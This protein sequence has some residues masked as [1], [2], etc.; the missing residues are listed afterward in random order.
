[1][2]VSVLLSKMILYWFHKHSRYGTIPGQMGIFNG[3]V[4]AH[5]FLGNDFMLLEEGNLKIYHV[6]KCYSTF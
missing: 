1:M 3:N 2:F 5:Q 6:V 4:I